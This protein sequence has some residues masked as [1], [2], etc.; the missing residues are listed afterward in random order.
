[1][2]GG[3]WQSPQIA[4]SFKIA[5]STIAGKLPQLQQLSMKQAEIGRKLL[6]NTCSDTNWQCKMCWRAVGLAE[7]PHCPPLHRKLSE[8]HYSSWKRLGSV[9]NYS[10]RHALTQI[11]NKDVLKG[12]GPGGSPPYPPLPLPKK[13]SQLQQFS[14]E[15]FSSTEMG[16]KL[17]ASGYSNQ[18]KIIKHI[19]IS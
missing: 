1:M 5:G 4:P 11:G 10:Q 8:L 14:T 19:W 7:A 16:R 9:T 13:L 18:Q 17:L 12:G 15:Q 2:A 6:A 3:N